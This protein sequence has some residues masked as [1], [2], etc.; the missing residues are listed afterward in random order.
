MMK[1]LYS[2]PALYRPAGMERVLAGKVNWLCRQTDG[3]GRPL[4]EVTVVTTDQMGRGHA[5]AMDGRV[6][7]VDLGIGYESNN[8][9][10]FVDKLVKYPFKQ[11]RHRRRLSR[12]LADERPDVVISMFGGDERFLTR[13]GDG[14]RKV[15]EVHFSRFK[16]LQYGRTGIWALADRLRSRRDEKV[17]R[18]FDRFVVLT[19]EDAGYWGELDNLRVI[20]NARTFTCDKPATTVDRQVI[21]VGRYTYQKGFDMLLD[22]WRSIDTTGWR[23]RIAG[24]GD[25]MKDLPDNVVTGL[26]DDMRS[27]YLHSSILALS[28]R[29]EG[30]PMV[31]LEAQA[32]GLPIV[33]FRCKCGPADVVTD[34]E[35]GLLVDEGDVASF[36]AALKR[37]MDDDDLRRRMGAA[38]YRNSD[39]FDEEKI[40]K[41]WVNLFEGL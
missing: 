40:M 38:A 11:L 34:G 30:L 37:L 35:D 15:L 9:A 26:S 25:E 36:A 1:L 32:A 28:S 27:E 21:A 16:R 4:Y 17:V 33:S 29:Y 14:S 7:F 22:A 41:L 23:L 6:R 2:I 19:R 5:F 31:L 12:L 3:E 10:S 20:P 8:G 18:R 13:I 39:R 24:A